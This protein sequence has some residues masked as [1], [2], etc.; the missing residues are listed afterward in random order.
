VGGSLEALRA[1]LGA[2][3]EL[4]WSAPEICA[5][6]IENTFRYL[7]EFGGGGGGGGSGPAAPGVGEG[8]DREVRECAR[9]ALEAMARA[10]D[11][12]EDI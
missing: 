10:F 12:S 9:R 4:T 1:A 7:V 6:V 2:I 5:A 3:I 8:V 11:A